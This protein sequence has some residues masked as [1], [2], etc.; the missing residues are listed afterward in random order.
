M[1]NEHNNCAL[2]SVIVVGL[3][4][5]ATSS[6]VAA[7]LS[8]EDYDYLRKTQSL[9]RHDAPVL[10]LGPKERSRLHDLINDPRSEAALRDMNVKD[11]L[12]LF[13]EHQLWEKAHPGE[14]WD[15]QRS[16]MLD[17]ADRRPHTGWPMLRN[18]H[19]WQADRRQ[20]YPDLS[21][22]YRR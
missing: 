10:N 16:E 2:A 6:A 8:D 11:A 17:A 18:D 5:A 7:G 21:V 13:L 19:R 14:L 9:E 4:L 20:G 12:A 15:N 22:G 1:R 3:L